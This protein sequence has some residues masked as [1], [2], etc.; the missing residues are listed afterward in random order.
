ML[1]ILIAVQMIAI[2]LL[3]I[4]ISFKVYK[5]DNSLG[6]WVLL[7]GYSSYFLT[8]NANNAIGMVYS[9]ILLALMIEA[10]KKIANRSRSKI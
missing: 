4:A 8:I 1:G 9:V 6:D 3:I 5:R 2:I 7:L 10:V